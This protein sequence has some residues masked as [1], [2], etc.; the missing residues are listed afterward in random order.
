M[1]SEN[2]MTIDELAGYLKVKKRTIYEWLKLKK[3]PAS[4]VIGQWRFSRN[5]IDK[6]LKIDREGVDVF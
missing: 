2:L 5:K 6:W 4:K 1:V 3:V